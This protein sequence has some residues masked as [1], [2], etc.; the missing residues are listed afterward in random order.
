MGEEIIQSN[1]SSSMVGLPA[2][3]FRFRSPDEG[4]GVAAS[5]GNGK[6]KNMDAKGA[7]ASAEESFVDK[8]AT[9]QHS[10]RRNG[11]KTLPIEEPVVVP[12]VSVESM[13]ATAYPQGK[14]DG[15]DIIVKSRAVITGK[16]YPEGRDSY[17]GRGIE[18]AARNGRHRRSLDDAKVPAEVYEGFDVTDDEIRCLLDSKGRNRSGRKNERSS[19]YKTASSGRPS[20]LPSSSSGGGKHNSRRFVF[21]MQ[22]AKGSDD[23]LTEEDYHYNRNGTFK[24]GRTGGSVKLSSQGQGGSSSDRYA[25]ARG[26]PEGIRSL[27]RN[28]P[29]FRSAQTDE[30]S[31]TENS[32]A[33]SDETIR[34]GEEYAEGAFYEGSDSQFSSAPSRWTDGEHDPRIK[35]RREHPSGAAGGRLVRESTRVERKLVCGQSRE[36]DGE[37]VTASCDDESESSLGELDTWSTVSTIGSV[38]GNDRRRLADNI[39]D[40]EGTTSFSLASS[41]WCPAPTR[42][43]GS[44]ASGIGRLA[45]AR[46]DSPLRGQFRSR[47]NILLRRSNSSL[48][49]GLRSLHQVAE[50]QAERPVLLV[51]GGINP[52]EP[53][54]EDLGT[55]VLRY[56]FDDDV[57]QLCTFMPQARSYHT[58]ACVG[59]CIYV[60]G[61]YSLDALDYQGPTPSAYCFCLDTETMTWK[62]CPPMSRARACH[63]CVVVGRHIYVAGGKDNTGSITDTVEY[64]D[65]DAVC[66]RS[67]PSLPQPLMASAAAYF[68]H[69]IWILGGVTQ[70]RGVTDVVFEFDLLGDR[71]FR[72]VDLWMPLAYSLALTTA[73]SSSGGQRLWLWGGMDRKCRS[74]GELC[75]WKPDR[76]AWKS[77]FRLQR[78]RDSFCG[79]AKGNLLCIVGG[80]E[81][82]RYPGASDANTQVDVAVKEAHAGCPLPYPLTGSSALLV[83]ALE[84]PSSF[85]TAKQSDQEST[86]GSAYKM[87]TVY[88]RYRQRVRV[89]DDD[90][91]TDSQFPAVG[92]YETTRIL[93]STFDSSRIRREEISREKSPTHGTKEERLALELRDKSRQRRKELERKREARRSEGAGGRNSYQILA[94]SVDPNLGLALVLEDDDNTCS[95]PY[96]ETAMVIDSIKRCKKV[97]SSATWGVLSFGGLD[98]HRPACHGTGRL[99]LYFGALKNSW[100][101]LD[102]MPEPRNYHTASLVGD[103]VFIVGGCDPGRTLSDEMVASD[104][105]FCF[106]TRQKSWTEK[107]KLPECRAFHGATVV[108]DQVY[109]V[110]GRDQNGSY[111]DTVAVYSPMLNAWSVVLKLPVALMGAAV[112]QHQ[113]LI[114]VL[115]G[116]AF[117][118]DTAAANCAKERFLDDVFIV[119]TRL[120]RCSRGPTLPFPRAFGAGAIC[121]GQIWLCGGLTHSSE[122]GKLVSTSNIHVLEDDTWVFYDVLALNRHAFVA[123]SYGS[124]DECEVFFAGPGHGSLRL[125]PPPF[126]LAGNACV[127]L[128]P[129]GGATLNVRDV[130]RRMCEAA[131]RK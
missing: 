69:R 17:Y 14:N 2:P 21:K 6:L 29:N 47:S 27:T 59:K 107:T 23:E 70:T 123:A 35:Q 18:V 40:E 65:V 115:G 48:H 71:W 60:L 95:A 34:A 82:C 80:T 8:R 19:E 108:G 81:S 15:D 96:S 126:R 10:F 61:G 33:D 41:C 76:R 113:G 9:V 90:E 56:V 66:W 42:S 5:V 13:T 116:V 36:T 104:S 28:A 4:R 94:P 12:A 24:S 25:S 38:R 130:W 64:Y 43:P 31:E 62:R 125:R 119:D 79:A 118:N 16:T 102:P 22:R 55:A 106:C 58:T 63:A 39:D 30:H 109:V 83:P 44:D 101:M 49:C 98:L 121:A 75:F 87:R 52:E 45:N 111:L 88:R 105:V 124:V 7:R 129:S 114:W 11:Q 32:N 1:S 53:L 78:P 77:Y 73:D 3:E 89:K 127:V 91:S 128:P 26:E 46:L 117:E 84:R 20:L 86:D 120:R 100:E 50:I 131:Q 93:E 57:W 97:T 54:R 92:V 67:V 110:G 74:V 122:N 112:V 103:E 68:E 85:R 99:V 37:Y 51:L 72:T